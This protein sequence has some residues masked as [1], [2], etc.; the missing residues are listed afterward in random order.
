MSRLFLEIFCGHFPWKLKDE[1]PRK[2]SPKLRRIF[3]R[4]LRKI[5]QELRS[6]GLRA[7][8]SARKNSRKNTRSMQINCFSAVWLPVRLFF[9]CSLSFLS[10][11]FGISLVNF[12]QGNSLVNLVFS[13]SF[14]R[15]CGFGR[16][17]KPLVILRFSLANSKKQRKG[18]TGFS[19][20]FTRSPPVGHPLTIYTRGLSGFLGPRVPE[21]V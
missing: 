7:Q 21:K 13:L 16:D 17:R 15:I 10:L 19:R 11:V 12:K 9:G 2:I 20:H 5:S 18:R 14:P 1:N 6:G 4:S 8:Q 3:R